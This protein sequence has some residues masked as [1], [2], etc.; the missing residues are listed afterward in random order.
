MKNVYW[1]SLCYEGAH[2]G[3][4]YLMDDHLL[5]RTNKLQLPDNMK[6]IRVPF[7]DMSQIGKGRTLYI[8][9]AIFITLRS[10]AR[11]K[12]IVFKRTGLFKVLSTAAA[13]YR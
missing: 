10:G 2:G 5:F 12:F 7:A 9:P 11:L 8:F 6:T 3:G 13:K 4:L 1:A